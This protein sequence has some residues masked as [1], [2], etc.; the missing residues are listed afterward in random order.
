LPAKIIDL[1][2]TSLDSM[3]MLAG[4]VLTLSPRS[5]ARLIYVNTLRK[6]AL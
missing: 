6:R 1:A 4:T 2:Q 3:L 5:V